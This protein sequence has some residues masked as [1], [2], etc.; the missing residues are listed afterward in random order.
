MMVRPVSSHA[1]HQTGWMRRLLQL[2]FFD[3]NLR[4][5]YLK[6]L[7]YCV[8]RFNATDRANATL[9]L[10]SPVKFLRFV[11]LKT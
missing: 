3:N 4:R 2:I 6:L 7:G 11:S 10:K 9:A 5:M 8:H 1:C